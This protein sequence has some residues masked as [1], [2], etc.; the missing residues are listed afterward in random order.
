MNLKP[1]GIAGAWL[2]STDLHRDDRGWLQ[3]TFDDEAYA[4]HGID[5]SVAQGSLVM[6]GKRG[7]IR[8][9]HFQ[10]DP[11]GEQKIITCVSGSIYDVLMDVRPSSPT[12]GKWVGLHLA[13]GDGLTLVVPPGVAHG[14]QTLEDGVGLWYL[15]NTKY[16]PEAARGHRYDDPHFAVPWPLVPDERLI[17]ER[18]RS[19]PRFA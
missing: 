19:W 14:Y 7:T 13:A 11:H 6:N 8:G 18:D 5:T 16:V 17:S 2:A 9:M 15:M 12:V 1:L 10:A 3:R 4:R